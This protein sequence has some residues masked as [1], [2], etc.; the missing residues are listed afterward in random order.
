MD[1]VEAWKDINH[2]KYQISNKGRV[3]D[4]NR[5]QKQFY[6][7][8]GYKQ[9]HIRYENGRR[10]MEIVHRL[11]A[12]YFIDNPLGK[13]QVNHKNE[14]KD[15]NSYDNLEWVTNKENKNY[16]TGTQRQSKKLMKPVLNITTGEIFPS[17]MNASIKYNLSSRTSIQQVCNNIKGFKTAGGCEWRYVV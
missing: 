17:A 6:D 4:G 13:P 1:F 12:I 11:V 3:T 16:G 14:I 5:I 15:S 2:S 8:K 10:T 7:T 9:V